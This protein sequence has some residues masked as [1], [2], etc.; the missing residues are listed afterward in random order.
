MIRDY[1]L[2]LDIKTIQDYVHNDVLKTSLSANKSNIGGWQSPIVWS[3]PKELK[4]QSIR[5][6]HYGSI[7]MDIKI[8][9]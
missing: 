5:L 8:L 6:N 2:K 3:W 1:T 4:Y 7:E 9:I